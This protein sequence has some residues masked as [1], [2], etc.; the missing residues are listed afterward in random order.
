MALDLTFYKQ[1]NGMHNKIKIKEWN[2]EVVKKIRKNEMIGNYVPKLKQL[3][4]Y[5][6]WVHPVSLKN[7]TVLT[8]RVVGLNIY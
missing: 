6:Y 4:R 3:V 5:N 2:S 8:I 1:W 7:K